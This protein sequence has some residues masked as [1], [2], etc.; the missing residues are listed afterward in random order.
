MNESE[1]SPFSFVYLRVLWLISQTLETVKDTKI[2]KGT[3]RRCDGRIRHP[4]IHLRA[5]E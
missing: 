5:A 2:H 1:D 3:H 4:T